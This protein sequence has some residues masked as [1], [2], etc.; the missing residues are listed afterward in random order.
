[1]LTMMDLFPV[2]V[3]F[4]FK[5]ATAL[6]ALIILWL[7][8]RFFDRE[9]GGCFTLWKEQANPHDMAIY[10]AGRFVGACLLFGLILS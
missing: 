8:L 9:T 3:A 7:T 6:A 4:G 10:Y 1:M 5:L 2:L